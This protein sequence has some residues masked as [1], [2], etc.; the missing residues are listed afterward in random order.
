MK[1]SNDMKPLAPNTQA[2]TISEKT[3]MANALPALKASA[4]AMALGLLTACGGSGDNID[5]DTL[6]DSDQGADRNHYY[7]PSD[8]Y[9][10]I[11]YDSETLQY[12][13]E[14]SYLEFSYADDYEGEINQTTVLAD[15]LPGD[16]LYS[17]V[18]IT[19]LAG[20]ATAQVSIQSYE[21]EVPEEAAEG[22]EAE[23][24]T[25]ADF[26]EFALDKATGF[27]GETTYEDDVTKLSFQKEATTVTNGTW[28]WIKIPITDYE[29]TRSV[30]LTVGNEV[31]PETSEPLT[32]SLKTAIITARSPAESTQILPFEF[33]D[34]TGLNSL[35]PLES[36]ISPAI[37]LTQMEQTETI[38]SAL[39]TQHSHTLSGLTTASTPI[40]I[41]SDLR[42]LDGD[43][44]ADDPVAMYRIKPRGAEGFG[45]WTSETGTVSPF[46]R[47]EVQITSSKTKLDTV[48]AKLTIG[49][50]GVNAVSQS[51]TVGTLGD[52]DMSR[53]VLFPPQSSFTNA[54]T[55]SARGRVL[56]RDT[57]GDDTSLETLVLKKEVDGLEETI[58]LLDT[59]NGAVSYN[60]ENGLWEAELVLD[61]DTTA[62]YTLEAVALQAETSERETVTSIFNLT[63]A[64]KD[65]TEIGEMRFP[66]VQEDEPELQLTNAFDVSVDVANNRYIVNNGQFNNG[67]LV[68]V[69]MATSERTELVNYHALLGN[70]NKSQSHGVQVD[71]QN[72]RVLISDKAT[73]GLTWYELSKI[74]G[75]PSVLVSQ[76]PKVGKGSVLK[77]IVELDMDYSRN[78]IVVASENGDNRYNGLHLV[79]MFSGGRCQYTDGKSSSVAV[80][81]DRNKYLYLQGN[82][83]ENLM[84]VDIVPVSDIGSVSSCKQIPTLFGPTYSKG[85]SIAVVSY[86]ELEAPMALEQWRRDDN[87]EVYF[88]NHEITDD[89]ATE[90][91]E[92][93]VGTDDQLGFALVGDTGA[94]T[95][96]RVDLKTGNR[97]VFSDA[98]T[99]NAN[100]PITAPEAVVVEYGLGF[101]VVAEKLTGTIFGVD[102]KT[103]Q[104]VI[105]TK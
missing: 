71:A 69:D 27:Y 104:R 57:A 51:W 2:A 55:L 26:A 47:V 83:A 100:V 102:L 22:D 60:H 78:L 37:E 82:S 97:E 81:H 50:E 54:L 56:L 77:Q 46:D 23:A 9:A 32:D 94:K 20:D 72:N 101:A 52:L 15:A 53:G 6:A 90:E 48:S 89:P 25:A 33:S 8:I 44:E 17:R 68:A 99:P 96:Y 12:Q 18:L 91:N 10:R 75:T 3:T 74:S 5:I 65:Q 87:G 36:I 38:I 67:H 19:G 24:A 13:A 7:V 59:A 88:L 21:G 92:Q 31:N 34:R 49:E 41:E 84:E 39:E 4:L 85:R 1:L 105:I 11:Q 86:K 28:V 79:D 14:D 64:N 42:D 62:Q 103:K 30:K 45:E 40:A 63:Q 93:L 66:E 43:G 61:Q 70:P 16:F 58:D 80:D 98:T 35:Q 95:I 73:A 29:Q 76:N